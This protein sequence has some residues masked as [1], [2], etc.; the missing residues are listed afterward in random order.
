MIEVYKS[1][2][3]NFEMNGDI[4]LDPISAIFKIELNGICEVEIEHSYDSIG[5]WKY[6]K[7]D[8]VVSGSTPWSSKQLFRIYDTEKTLTGIKVYARH[9]FFDLVKY[10]IISNLHIKNKNG[11]EAL[12]KILER[13]PY[14]PHSNIVDTND[15]YFFK[16]NVIQG[17]SGSQEN[18]FLKRWGGEI[19]LDN[20]E[21]YINSRIG[22][23]YGVKISYANNMESLALKRNM[24][25][26]ITRLYPYVTKNT[27]DTIELPEDFV[28]SE[29]IDKYAQVYEQYID[30]SEYMHLK[31]GEDDI[32]NSYETEEE[33]YEAMR[34]K[35]KELFREGLDKPK[36]SG[37]VNMILLENTIEYE[38]VKGLIN[39][40]LGDDIVVEH[41]DIGVETTTRCV[42]YTW[43]MVNE[44]YLDINLGEIEKDYFDVQSNTTGN[45]NNILNPNGSINPSKLEGFINA[46]KSPLIAQKDIAAK[47]DVIAWKTEVTDP[48]DP[49]FGCMISGTKGISISDRRT[50]D[51]R[52]WVY[53]LA[54]SARGI[55]ADLLIGKIVAGSGAYFDLNHGEIYF[56]KGLIRGKNSEWNLETG[57]IKSRLQDG[58][59]LIISPTKGF[60]NKFGN[61]ERAYHHLSYT[62]FVTC[63]INQGD[64]SIKLP[65]EFKGKDFMVI[66]SPVSAVVD[67]F[68]PTEA[69]RN[70][71]VAVSVDYK[72]AIIKPASNYEYIDIETKKTRKV[73]CWANILVVA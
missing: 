46:I 16:N 43:D 4:T 34:N 25:G 17:I 38:H 32:E 3:K 2:N 49:N 37:S 59:E 65:N 11:Q 14:I 47:S 18:T 69:L 39:V 23:D 31:D 73:K 29:N 8:A 28:D 6:L 66:V 70:V 41:L 61:S 35:C 44:K 71:G 57:E 56:N 27:S 52:D 7:E 40:G 15:C 24:E 22:G 63:P 68:K 51:G 12:D 5:R 33:L 20:F 19:F 62:E 50:P 21:V 72:N 64:L 53:D 67:S 1:H 60:Y 42:G 48:D 54:I 36:V 30:L 10:N 45:L 9:I 58:S 26:V 55:I 13:T